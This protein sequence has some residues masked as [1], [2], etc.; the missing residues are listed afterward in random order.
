MAA[1]VRKYCESCDTCQRSKLPLPAR[2][3]LVS[4]PVGR[5]WEFVA[6]D[7]LKVPPSFQ[8]NTYLLVLQ[9][10]FT[11]WLEAVLLAD[12]KAETI[13]KDLV[14][15]FSVFGMPKYLHSDQ[16]TNFESTILQKTS[17]AFG[18]IKTHTLKPVSP[19]RRWDGGEK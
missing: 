13:V 12:Q 14:K 5:P 3:P 6:V 1:D 2:A 19:A 7:I 15:I 8:G 18:I 10:Y 4:M 16:G 17:E 11:K 9:D